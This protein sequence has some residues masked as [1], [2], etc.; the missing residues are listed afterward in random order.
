MDDRLVTPTPNQPEGSP[1]P[2]QTSAEPTSESF[3][4]VPVGP[5]TNQAPKPKR[6]KKPLLLSLLVIL[7]IAGAGYSV[8]AWQHKKVNDLNT[9]VASLQSQITSLNSQINDLKS[10]ASSSSSTQADPYAGWKTYTSNSE[11]ASFKYPS[12]WTTTNPPSGF[13]STLDS[14][15]LKSPNETVSVSWISG[16]IAGVGGC[17]AT[18]PLGSNLACPQV[19]VVNKTAIT[20]AKGLYVV[21][22]TVTTDG[23]TFKPWMAVQDSKGLLTSKRVANY[24]MYSGLQNKESVLFSIDGIVAGSNSKGYSSADKAKAYLNGSEVQQAKLILLSLTY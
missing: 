2:F 21:E 11:K 15:G 22:G 5:I 18:A 17:N 6:S 13:A 19:N 9:Q 4:E 24:D 12:N 8:Y 14:I 23:K 3:P 1:S 7:L 20:N 16:S 10:A